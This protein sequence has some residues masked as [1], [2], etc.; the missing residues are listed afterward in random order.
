MTYNELYIDTKKKLEKLNGLGNF[1][2]GVLLMAS[3]IDDLKYVNEYIQANPNCKPTEITKIA[4]FLDVLRNEP[5][6]IY[7]EDEQK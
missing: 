1:V 4:L 7:E 6:R 3:H 2:E 5:T